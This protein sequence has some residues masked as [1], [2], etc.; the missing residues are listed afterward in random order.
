MIIKDTSIEDLAE[1]IKNP[2]TLVI[3]EIQASEQRLN[4][5]MDKLDGRIGQLDGRL[6]TFQTE[7]NLR[8][9]RV[10][11]KLTAI[12]QDIKELYGMLTKIQKD[13]SELRKSDRQLD[14]RLRNLEDFAA[15]ISQ[16]TG[17]PFQP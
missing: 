9:D 15:A 2:G 13:V 14:L 1:S 11:D 16:K 7:T 4:G 10:E 17:V 8:F 5:R 12:E 6:L 3:G